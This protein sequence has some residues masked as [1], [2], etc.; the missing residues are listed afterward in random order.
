MAGAKGRYS[1]CQSALDRVNY[2]RDIEAKDKCIQ[3]YRGK[4]EI[5][6]KTVQT[7]V[8]PH[9]EQSLPNAPSAQNSRCDPH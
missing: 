2:E 3:P 1:Y 6:T 7:L 4:N 9:R 8:C 5:D